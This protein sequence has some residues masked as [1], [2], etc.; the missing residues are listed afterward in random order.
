MDK[1]YFNRNIFFI[2]FILPTFLFSQGK[3][4]NK[5]LKEGYNTAN[6]TYYTRFDKHHKTSKVDE[7]MEKNGYKILKYSTSDW[8]VYG[9]SETG[10]ENIY[11]MRSSDYDTFVENAK[12]LAAQENKGK[13]TKVEW[14]DFI[15][16]LL[17]GVAIYKGVEWYSKQSS[18]ANSY[19]KTSSN[20]NQNESHT[21]STRANEKNTKVQ[22]PCYS[23][24]GEYTKAYVGCNS[25]EYGRL[26]IIKV[27]CGNGSTEYYYFISAD[28][29]ECIFH[30]TKGYYD[31]TTLGKGYLG[32]DYEKAM[33]ELCNCK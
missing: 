15:A 3:Q 13:V 18:E 9:Y 30:D 26:P 24:I 17:A 20:S 6:R 19:S 33:K 2:I 5:A 14:T 11:F 29:R 4:L 28:R 16:P 23:D 7:W 10:Y 32:K 27:K 21:N 31:H 22:V 12:R 25:T 1:F 8:P